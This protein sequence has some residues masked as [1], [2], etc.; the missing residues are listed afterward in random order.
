[1]TAAISIIVMS[2]SEGRGEGGEWRQEEGTERMEVGSWRR[3]GVGEWR[4][5]NLLVCVKG[6]T[7]SAG[8]D[9]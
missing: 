9:D 3:D 8:V 2:S 5:D 4:E 6:T 1:M 7:K